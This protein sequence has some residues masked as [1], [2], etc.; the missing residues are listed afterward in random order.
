[1]E[2]KQALS[3]HSLLPRFWDIIVPGCLPVSLVVPSAFLLDLS[4]LPLNVG[5]PQ[6]AVLS[7]PLFSLLILP[8]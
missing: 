2:D 6:S 8:R 7:P 5:R 1:M 4:Q 3:G